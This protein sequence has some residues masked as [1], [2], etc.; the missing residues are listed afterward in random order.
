M[1]HYPITTYS[2]PRSIWVILLWL[3]HDHRLSV[4]D[5]PPPVERYY[6]VLDKDNGVCTFCSR[7]TLG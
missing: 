4:C 5:V 6:V 7:H 2:E 3:I 1:M